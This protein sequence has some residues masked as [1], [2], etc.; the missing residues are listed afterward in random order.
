MAPAA[1]AASSRPDS[2]AGAV[3]AAREPTGATPDPALDGTPEGVSAADRRKAR[4]AARAHAPAPERNPAYAD[5]DL[6]ELREMRSTLGA[7]ETRVSYWRRIIQARL[8]VLSATGSDA[9]RIA[10]LSSVLADA[11]VAHHRLANIDA[12]PVD[13]VPPLPDLAVLWTRVADPDDPEGT[14]A[15][16]EALAAA[17]REI[18]AFRRE[19]HRRIDAVTAEL[20]ARY[21]DNPLLAL[22]VLPQRPQRLMRYR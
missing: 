9:E 8:D 22:T 10:D 21:R 13:D 1:A 7:E 17:E 12:L 6:H 20:I 11:P 15:L 19:L 3:P 2:A 18:S 14:R 4:K 5:L 16:I